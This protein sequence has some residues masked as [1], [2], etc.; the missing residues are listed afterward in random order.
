MDTRLTANVSNGWKA[1]FAV[2]T[3]TVMR[4]TFALIALCSLAACRGEP[5]GGPSSFSVQARHVPAAPQ[6]VFI[7]VSNQ[8]AE[9]L[10][11]PSAEVRLGSGLINV[12]PES[13][14]DVFENRPP[15][16]L[17]GGVDVSEGVQVIPPNTKRDLFL[18][19][20]E[21]QGRRPAP[22]GVRGKVHALSCR[23]L[24]NSPRPAVAE[25]TFEA[26]FTPF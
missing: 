8:S 19:L 5:T 10:C 11:V 1:D 22:T 12:L 4:G 20:S 2:A 7:N 23:E 15:P 26:R 13:R 9:Y 25:Q 21:L 3:P 6:T 16:D 17:L 24:F 18:D 14:S